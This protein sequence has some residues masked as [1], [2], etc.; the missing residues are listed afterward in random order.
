M[1]VTRLCLVG[2]L[3]AVGRLWNDKINDY[4]CTTSAHT[5]ESAKVRRICEITKKEQRAMA[6]RTFQ[7]PKPPHPYTQKTQ[8]TQFAH[9]A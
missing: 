9:R 7:R 8:F 4:A 2:R 1:G 3:C 6:L 5:I